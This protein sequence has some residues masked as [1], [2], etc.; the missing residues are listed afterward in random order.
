MTGFSRQGIYG[1]H[2]GRFKTFLRPFLRFIQG[3][4]LWML[5]QCARYVRWLR[6]SGTFALFLARLF[7]SGLVFGGLIGAWLLLF[8]S[9]LYL[10]LP[11]VDEVGALFAAESTVITD[12]NGIELYRI[13]GDEDRTLMPLHQ[14]GDFVKQ[15]TIAIEDQRF[16]ERDCFDEIGFT[17]AV[18][19][20]VLP[21]FL[22]R[23]G[24]STITQQ[25]SKNALIGH[26][27]KKISRKF[28]EYM[29]SC[30]LEGRYSKDEILEL[31][32][33]RIPYGHNAHGVEQA[34]Q[35]YFAQS[36]SGLTIAE[37][38]VLAALPQLP[39]YLS[40]YGD[41]VR[42]TLSEK[43]KERVKSGRLRSAEDVRDDDF[44]LGL[45]GECF[46]SGSTAISM[47][48]DSLEKNDCAG[49]Y[50]GGRTDQVLKNM[51][52][53]G[54]ITTEQRQQALAELQ[55]IT[56]R[57]AREN[58][59]APHFVLSVREMLTEKFRN[60]FDPGFLESGGLTITTTLDF[61]LQQKAEAI[62]EE[63]GQLNIDLYDAHNAALIAV[64]VASGEILT[65]VGNR[66][67]WDEENDG[68]VDIV[69]APRQPGSSFKPFSYA[70]AF[71][72]G[73]SPATV[74]YDVPT[75][76]GDDR[77][78]NFDSKFWGPTTIRRALGASRNIPAAKSYF[79]AGGEKAIV[80][81]AADMGVPTVRERQEELSSARGEPYEYGWPLSLGAAEVP[82]YEMV[83]GYTTFARAGK[84]TDFISVL[85]IE[86]R[87]GNILYSAPE[88]SEE[89]DVLDPRVAYMITSI[90]SD[91]SARPA[92]FWRDQLSIPE[93]QTAAKTG[94]SNKCLKRDEKSN[95]CI[96]SKPDNTWT[97]GYTPMI[98]AGA[99]A[100]NAS[101]GVLEVKASGLDTAS[102]IWRRFMVAA[103]RDIGSIAGAQ[104]SQ[105][106]TRDKRDMTKQRKTTF[107]IPDGLAS[108]QISEL[109]GKLAGT[110]TPEEYR[111]AEIFFEGEEP[112]EFDDACL[113]VEIDKLTGLLASNECPAEARE[114][115]AHFAPRSILPDRWPLWEEGVQQWAHDLSRSPLHSR[116]NIADLVQ[117]LSYEEE[118]D[119]VFWRTV[120]V[121]EAT[122][123][124]VRVF[125]GT[126]AFLPLP[127]PLAPRE[128]CTLVLTPG[129]LLRP[130]LQILSPSQGGSATAP[131]FR[132]EIHFSVGDTVREVRYELDGRIVARTEGSVREPMIRL[133]RRFDISGTHSL[134]VT[135]VDSYFN[136]V[137]DTV[138][139]SFREDSGMPQVS[140]FS[141]QPGSI[142]AIGSKVTVRVNATDPGGSIDRVQFFLGDELLTTRREAP[143]EATFTVQGGP[144]PTVLRAVAM[145]SAKNEG[146]D[147]M[148]VT[149]EE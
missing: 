142:L 47:S 72:N 43:G 115:G 128:Q 97:I 93:F 7:R 75:Q 118:K 35:I 14:I 108:A 120:R 28:R 132:P 96:N 52:D 129:R 49:I 111:R 114:R 68:N 88:K 80:N 31:Y 9:H 15:A 117:P 83:Q 102:H 103:H 100:G 51:E 56:F 66:D 20:Q 3:T 2:S 94:T 85:R 107:D 16:Y 141:P 84:A 76:I 130:T 106:S 91:E 33:N 116:T 99:W 38:S 10:T 126:G 65:Y 89:R 138:R 60:L 77:P 95:I 21:G 63:L 5:M 30:K 149:L 87:L 139:F 11:N 135:I 136:E 131:S 133:P 19:S 27:K 125:R 123:E 48:F 58:I 119:S 29:L 44:W 17:R 36:A 113:T 54:F 140:I 127:L 98:A 8:L 86:D 144:G 67:Y 145:D 61:G 143:Y 137:S 109:S 79:L 4:L 92:G 112:K 64:N 148:S 45:V 22:V 122:G 90:L 101:G 18:L 32:L 147:E 121:D 105:G 57:R 6:S 13:H 110:C 62:I 146:V 24:G 124:P 78:E 69:R 26:R 53:Q 42:T 71:L 40:P 81:L 34:S 104:R 23:S 70:A 73:Y 12:R 46:G 39:S 74:L 1:R 37:A 59:R 41:H 55:S 50:I 82:L 25:F 134:R